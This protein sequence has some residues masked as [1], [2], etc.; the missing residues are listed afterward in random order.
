MTAK[1]FK[2]FAKERKEHPGFTVKQ[3]WQIVKDHKKKKR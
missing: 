1:D 3:V 2:M